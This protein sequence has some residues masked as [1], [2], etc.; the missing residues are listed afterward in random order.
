MSSYWMCKDS[1]TRKQPEANTVHQ[2]HDVPELAVMWNNVCFCWKACSVF[3]LNGRHCRGTVTELAAVLLNAEVQ[4]YQF[5]MHRHL[6]LST[7]RTKGTELCA[8]L[9]QCGTVIPMHLSVT[10]PLCAMLL[11]CAIIFHDTS[12]VSVFFSTPNDRNGK[13][14]RT[15]EWRE[16]KVMREISFKYWT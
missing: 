15:S 9:V 13:K 2:T 14:K 1:D 3:S 16:T 4:T 10:I 7:S 6:E 5:Q 11:N 12:V 8:S